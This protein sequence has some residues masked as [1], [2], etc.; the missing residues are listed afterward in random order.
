[1]SIKGTSGLR[2]FCFLQGVELALF[3]SPRLKMRPSSVLSLVPLAAALSGLL[4]VQAAT[5]KKTLTI[6]NTQL[7]PDGFQRE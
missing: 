1:M 4:S 5:V 7:A 3:C 6:V 2:H